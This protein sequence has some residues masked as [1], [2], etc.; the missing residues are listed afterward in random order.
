MT[1]L[2]GAELR[3]RFGEAPMLTMAEAG[4]AL[5]KLGLREEVHP[6]DVVGFR[7]AT[8]EGWD[9]SA[10]SNLE[11]HGHADLGS[12]ATGDGVTGLLDTRHCMSG[13]LTGPWLPD[14]WDPFE[15]R[16][17][18][19]REALA[20]MGLGL[21]RL[22][23]GSYAITGE[24]RSHRD[25]GRTFLFL[26]DVEQF[27]REQ[28]ELQVASK[29]VQSSGNTG[30]R[31]FS[32]QVHSNFAGPKLDAEFAVVA[33]TVYLG[34]DESAKVSNADITEAL[35]EL[36]ERLGVDPAKAH[37]EVTGAAR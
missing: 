2:T 33:A 29:A 10:R 27:I 19:V 11:H 34:E 31:D 23:G 28:R 4:D 24:D 25:M 14:D 17:A 7:Y 32:E 18:A 1:A 16:V 6:R 5:R 36:L 26:R 21:A 20:A 15:D 9:E 12:F 22:D 13:A 8:Q 35:R 3:E 37:V 30:P